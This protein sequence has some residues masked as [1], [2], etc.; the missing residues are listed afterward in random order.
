MESVGYTIKEINA[1]A[2]CQVYTVAAM[3]DPCLLSVVQEVWSKAI[4]K[5]NVP[6]TANKQHFHRPGKAWVHKC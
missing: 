4:I 6:F 5:T 3:C 2:D 1:V